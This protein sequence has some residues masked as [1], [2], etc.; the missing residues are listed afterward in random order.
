MQLSQVGVNLI[1]SFEGCVLHAYK[2]LPTEKY[3]TIG[4]GHYGSDV[5]E[6][7]TITSTQ[8]EELLKQDL[9][10]YEFAVISNVK[11]SLNQYQYDALVSLCYNIGTEGFRTSTL[12]EKLNQHDYTG[13]AAEFDRWVHS[14]GKVI[15]GLVN[16]RKAE[17]T[18]FLKPVEVA[19]VIIKYT[20]KAGD[21]LTAIASKYHT[22]V[23][24]IAKLNQIVNPN[25][26]YAGQ[27]LKVPNITK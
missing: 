2:A 1:K 7:S 4:Y 17:K 6:G 14:G 24:R 11:V 15:Q 25:K 21:N 27:V 18:L 26:I 5:R 22:T 12:L 9:K 19:P 10:K 20:V 3:F 16:R 13:A 8:A 23:D